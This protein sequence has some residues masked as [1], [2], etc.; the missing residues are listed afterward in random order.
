M[1]GDGAS[2]YG[3]AGDA[4][5]AAIAAASAWANGA[6]SSMFCFFVEVA[7]SIEVPVSPP[8]LNVHCRSTVRAWS[9]TAVT[10]SDSENVASRVI[11]KALRR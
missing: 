10:A 11:G 2:G 9:P 8:K 5:A 1:P 3:M 4:D 6:G 7:T